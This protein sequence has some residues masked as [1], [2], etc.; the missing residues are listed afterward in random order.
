MNYV[1]EKDTQSNKELK[2][3]L[4][5]RTGYKKYAPKYDLTKIKPQSNNQE[6]IT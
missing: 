6:R 3:E 4:N 1:L 2:Y 5:K